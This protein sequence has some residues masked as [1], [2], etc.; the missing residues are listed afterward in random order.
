M[1]WFT[2][3]K[4]APVGEWV[5][6]IEF[7]SSGMRELG[8]YTWEGPEPPNGRPQNPAE[9]PE[10]I[11]A[12]EEIRQDKAEEDRRAAIRARQNKQ[13]AAKMKAKSVMSGGRRKTKKNSKRS[14][15]RKTSGRR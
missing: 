1:G 14:Y 12:L 7:T 2:S 6:D 15:K 3:K 5:Q 9:T 8:T 11:A 10:G 13:Y 4:P